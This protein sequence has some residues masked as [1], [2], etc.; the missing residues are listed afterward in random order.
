M[1]QTSNMLYEA[2]SSFQRYFEQYAAVMK[3]KD[4]ISKYNENDL[5]LQLTQICMCKAP[6]IQ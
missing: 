3:I 5:K 2:T 1:R 4:Q 6:V